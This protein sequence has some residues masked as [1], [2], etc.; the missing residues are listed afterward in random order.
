MY[1]HTKCPFLFIL[2][3]LPAPGPPFPSGT[4]CLPSLVGLTLLTWEADKP[5]P[6]KVIPVDRM[7][8]EADR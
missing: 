5:E 6:K 1:R 2:Y 8:P 7:E 3:P 4:M